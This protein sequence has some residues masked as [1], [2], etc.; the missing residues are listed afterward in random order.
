MSHL[1]R[2]LTDFY[3]TGR[4]DGIAGREPAY[5]PFDCIDSLD[6][7]AYF[8][9]YRDGRAASELWCEFCPGTGGG[10]CVC[11]RTEESK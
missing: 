3:G 9:G 10:C 8:T 6:V 11:G 4:A 1:H 2:P 5:D 7:R